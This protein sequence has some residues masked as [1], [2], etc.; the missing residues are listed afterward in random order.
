L[1][2][3]IKNNNSK[4]D[5]TNPTKDIAYYC[6]KFVRKLQEIIYRQ[7]ELIPFSIR[8]MLKIVQTKARKAT[9][10]KTEEI[11]FV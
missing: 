7:R 3:A 1:I 8:A 11:K 9:E 4:I 6:I 2:K 5:S 10:N